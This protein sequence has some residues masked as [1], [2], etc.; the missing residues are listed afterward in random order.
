MTLLGLAVN[1]SSKTR[2]DETVLSFPPI[3]NRTVSI[4]S[5]LLLITLGT[6]SGF[7]G[8]GVYSFRAKRLPFFTKNS[9]SV[10]ESEDF[11]SRVAE[12]PNMAFQSSMYMLY[13]EDTD[14][15]GIMYNS[16][17][18]K[19]AER[20]LFTDFLGREACCLENNRTIVSLVDQRF[21]AAAQLGAS[22]YLK[23]ERREQSQGK[24]VWYIEVRN[25]ETLY[26][27]ILMEISD[28]FAPELSLSETTT[29][30]SN[31][32]VDEFS[33]YRDEFD[34]FRGVILLRSILNMFERS[35][36][37]KFW[38]RSSTL[39]RFPFSPCLLYGRLVGWTRWS[40]KAKRRGWH[41]L[42]SHAS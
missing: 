23:G 32:F 18:L 12:T 27:T 1:R 29:D 9:A 11:S 7:I 16:N 22:F 30:V 21:K 24:E 2:K 40:Q 4:R 14:S 38:V 42:R 35:R 31:L 33:V 20:A 26:N 28:T 6:C 36:S 37:S 10:R 41:T 8:T 17:Y 25:D 39:C 13:I 3:S 19:F 34:P 15:Y 5:I